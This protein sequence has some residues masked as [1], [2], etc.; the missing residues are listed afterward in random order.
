ME[1]LNGLLAI[2][3]QLLFTSFY[4]TFETS[5]SLLSFGSDQQKKGFKEKNFTKIICLTIA[6]LCRLMAFGPFKGCRKTLSR[7]RM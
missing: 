2:S 7:V 3:P 1:T 5:V 6:G 4:S